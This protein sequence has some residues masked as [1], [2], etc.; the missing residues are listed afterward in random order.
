MLVNKSEPSKLAA[1]YLLKSIDAAHAM[2][3][4]YQAT[5]MVSLRDHQAC[6]INVL[7][8]ELT[9]AFVTSMAPLQ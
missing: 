8:A 5:M 1:S 9:K 4:N 2:A 3:L 7:V 6:T